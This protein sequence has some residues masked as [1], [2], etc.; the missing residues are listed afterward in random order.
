MRDIC[1]YYIIILKFIRFTLYIDTILTMI[2]INSK[3]AKIHITINTK[4]RFDRK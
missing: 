2:Y 4:N 1:M 3:I